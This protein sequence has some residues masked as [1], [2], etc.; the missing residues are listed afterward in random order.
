VTKV[1]TPDGV[2]DVMSDTDDLETAVE[3]FLSDADAAYEEYDRGY[4]DAD[5]TLRQLESAIEQLR[6]AAR[7][8]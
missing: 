2:S 7:E 6:V 8:E 5:A 4:I 3:T 1:F